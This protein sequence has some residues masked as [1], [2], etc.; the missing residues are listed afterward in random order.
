MV[1]TIVTQSNGETVY[2]DDP[3]PSFHF[4]KLISCSLFN[5]WH[6]LKIGDSAELGGQSICINWQ[7][8]PRTLL[9]RLLRAQKNIFKTYNY[10]LETETNTSFGL[11]K[12]VN[13]GT[14]PITLDGD[15]AHLLGINRKLKQ[16][17][18][19][20]KKAFISND[21]LRSL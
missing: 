10:N 13:H 1:L 8:A 16:T 7:N 17:T 21:I 2:F 6:T 11:L 3:I 4:M 12:I 14:K 15:L 18:Y 9:F 19:A 5:S 20:N